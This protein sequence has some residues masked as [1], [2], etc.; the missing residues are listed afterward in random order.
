MEPMVVESTETEYRLTGTAE[1]QFSE[2][3][4]LLYQIYREENFSV[5]EIYTYISNPDEAIEDVDQ[6]SSN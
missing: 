6:E 4:D 3:Q 1:Q 2:W 5:D